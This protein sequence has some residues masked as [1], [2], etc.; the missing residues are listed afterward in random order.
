MPSRARDPLG[1]GGRV[2]NLVGLD[3]LA[4]NLSEVLEAFVRSFLVQANQIIKSS[5]SRCICAYYWPACNSYTFTFSETAASLQP[6]YGMGRLDVTGLSDL[7]GGR[8]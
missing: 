4:Q 3:D 1:S 5:S 2:E 8:V 6:I 7:H